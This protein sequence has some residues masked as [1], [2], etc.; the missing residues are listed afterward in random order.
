ME[1]FLSQ[2]DS[3]Y[4]CS[5]F[6]CLAAKVESQYLQEVMGLLSNPQSSSYDYI[7]KALFEQETSE[8]RELHF[9]YDVYSSLRKRDNEMSKVRYHECLA[10]LIVTLA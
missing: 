5:V 4:V 10:S 1:Y 6:C 2:Q 7:I 9:D 8:Q 3:A